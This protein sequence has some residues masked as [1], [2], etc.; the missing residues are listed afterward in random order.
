[1]NVKDIGSGGYD[2][3]IRI[4]LGQQPKYFAI[5]SQKNKPIKVAQSLE[6]GYTVLRFASKGVRNV[7]VFAGESQQRMDW[8]GRY[9][10]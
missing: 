6:D 8:L 7:I 2:K 5:T 4:K 1:M 9:D 3:E 10:L